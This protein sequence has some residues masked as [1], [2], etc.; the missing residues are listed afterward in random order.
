MRADDIPAAAQLEE[1]YL[2]HASPQP[3]YEKHYQDRDKIYL[4]GVCEGVVEAVCVVWC[5][6]ETADLCAIVVSE[7][8]RGQGIAGRLLCRAFDICR[9]YGVERMILEVRESSR[10]AR[11]L[12][13]KL[14]FQPVCVRRLYYR[15]PTED[16]VV[17]QKVLH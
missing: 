13:A 15:E 5:S 3:E 17:M 1:H 2:S 14:H 6:F 12:Y 9:G 4:V 11:A 7:G 16:A 8:H 10:P